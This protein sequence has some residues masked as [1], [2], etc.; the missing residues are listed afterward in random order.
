[1]TDSERGQNPK[2]ETEIPLRERPIEEVAGVLQDV[3]GQALV[4]YAIDERI[5]QRLGAFVNS[6]EMPTEEAEKVMRDLAEVLEVLRERDSDD[7]VRAVMIGMN[8][9]LDE[10]A[11]IE[12]IHNGE[13]DRVVTARDLLTD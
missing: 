10:Q 11:P 5:P 4:A 7:V 8:P 13:S 9:M 2:H 12:L 1:M 6:E 3:L